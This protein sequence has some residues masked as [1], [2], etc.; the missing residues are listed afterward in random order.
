MDLRQLSDLQGGESSSDG[1]ED[2]QLGKKDLK[3]PVDAA[4]V[5]G[6]SSDEEAAT[7]L[8]CILIL[9]YFFL[10]SLIFLTVSY[11]YLWSVFKGHQTNVITLD[12]LVMLDILDM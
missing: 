3:K 7:T 12:M 1:D 5:G 6:S 9:D 10:S 2:L 11:D 4:A 8:P